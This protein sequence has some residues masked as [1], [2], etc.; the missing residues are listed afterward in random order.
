MRHLHIRRPAFS[1]K[2]DNP[3]RQLATG[4]ISLEAYRTRWALLTQRMQDRSK[5]QAP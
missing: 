5:A 1:F 2:I 3:I 4:S